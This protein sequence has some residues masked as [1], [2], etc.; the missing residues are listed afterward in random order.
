MN[1]S[2]KINLTQ[3]SE[4]LGVSVKTV[5]LL[6]SEGHIQRDKDGAVTV[7][8]AVHGY[9]A[10]IKAYGSR[11]DAEYKKVKTEELKHRVAARDGKYQQEAN[12]EAYQVFAEAWPQVVN[13]LTSLPAICSRDN[14]ERK[15]IRDVINAFQRKF[16]DF[17]KT[18]LKPAA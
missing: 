17:I 12:E 1:I 10:S 9:V 7:G 3:A 5:S 6:C 8:G 14:A 13:F 16:I 18:E 15:R 2:E 4:L 11:A